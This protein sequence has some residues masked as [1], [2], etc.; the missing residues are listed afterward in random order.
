MLLHNLLPKALAQAKLVVYKL[1]CAI[2]DHRLH[3]CRYTCTHTQIDTTAASTNNTGSTSCTPNADT[4]GVQCGTIEAHHCMAPGTGQAQE[5]ARLLHLPG[6]TKN[7][8]SLQQ[9]KAHR[10]SQH[11]RNPHCKLPGTTKLS[12]SH[13]CSLCKL[14]LPNQSSKD[15]TKQ[16]EPRIALEKLG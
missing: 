9:H 5:A 11:N 16:G 3:I 10:P 14:P 8:G 6:W 1:L 7:P 4:S 15:K 2:L 13:T 12:R